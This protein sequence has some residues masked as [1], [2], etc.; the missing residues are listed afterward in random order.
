M[1]TAFRYAPI[2]TDVYIQQP[3]GF[4]IRNG[5]GNLKVC[6]LLKSIYGLKQSGRNWH[7]ALKSHLETLDLRSSIN[8]PALFFSV[9]SRRQC[10]VAAWVDDIVYTSNDPEFVSTFERHITKR[11]TV[12]DVP[13]FG[14]SWACRSM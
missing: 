12:S 13:I 2:D 1:K 10:L 8:D 11:F 9:N 6:N 3:K 7:L 4:E 5:N 14:G